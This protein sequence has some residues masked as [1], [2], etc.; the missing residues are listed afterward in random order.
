MRFQTH[1]T[2]CRSCFLGAVIG[3]VIM[4]LGGISP[5][6]A[7][8]SSQQKVVISVWKEKV[9]HKLD[10][11]CRDHLFGIVF[12]ANSPV[13]AIDAGAMPCSHCV[14]EGHDRWRQRDTTLKREL[15]KFQRQQRYTEEDVAYHGEKADVAHTSAATMAAA[16]KRLHEKSKMSLEELI[17]AGVIGG[18]LPGTGPKI[19]EKKYEEKMKY[20]AASIAAY[21]QAA[22]FQAKAAAEESMMRRSIRAGISATE[23][24]AD[25]LDR[26]F[27]DE[28]IA[29][30]R[31]L[32][33]SVP[34]LMEQGDYFHA[35][36]AAKKWL[37]QSEEAEEEEY[38]QWLGDIMQKFIENFEHSEEWER[39]IVREVFEMASQGYRS[40]AMTWLEP[41]VAVCP[42]NVN[43][44]WMYFC[45][46][47]DFPINTP[48]DQ[49]WLEAMLEYR[50]SL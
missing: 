40:Y 48:M 17:I 45:L 21:R 39:R 41:A 50:K 10:G 25:F 2:L 7:D 14:P 46:M 20:K 4:Q 29:E 44:M 33:A 34:I 15:D 27:H 28:H 9:Y 37:S 16:G 42:R 38:A 18:L 23:R 22:R 32:K 31:L 35:Y 47:N 24:Y 43:I 6:L 30:Q 1:C 13:Q 19:L 11:P 26:F 12:Y 8:N 49:Q 36:V 5:A 3:V